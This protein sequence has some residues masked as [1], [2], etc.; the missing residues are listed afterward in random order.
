MI[1]EFLIVFAV[2]FWLGS[3]FRGAWMALS[4]REILKDLG[5]TDQQLRNLAQKN[6]LDLAEPEPTAR[7]ENAN[8][9]VLEVRV[10]Q[11]PEGLFAYRKSDSQFLAQG[12]DRETLMQNL[13]NNLTNVRVVV[14]KED[15]ADLIS[16]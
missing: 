15:G 4:F 16:S 9:P 11:Q 8:L 5:V 3:L 12:R 6:G 7:D 1:L 2:G 13:V 10:E 14:A